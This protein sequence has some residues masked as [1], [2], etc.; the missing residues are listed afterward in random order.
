M[1]KRNGSDTVAFLLGVIALAPQ[2]VGAVKRH[3]HMII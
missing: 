3:M 2:T 1:K